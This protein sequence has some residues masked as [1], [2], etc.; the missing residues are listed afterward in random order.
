VDFKKPL[1]EDPDRLSIRPRKVDT[2]DPGTYKVLEGTTFVK[3]RNPNF[4][5]GKS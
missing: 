3:V 2:P 4:S 5:I 1:K